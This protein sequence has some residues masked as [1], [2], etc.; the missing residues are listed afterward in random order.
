[1]S[2]DRVLVEEMLRGD[3]DAFARLMRKYQ[4]PLLASAYHLLGQAE[5]AQDVA[6][7]TFIEAYRCLPTLRDGDKLRA[8]L[9]AMLRFRCL[10]FRR[11]RRHV[12]V[13]LEQI[14]DLPASPAPEFA[15][16]A[17]WEALLRLPLTDREIIAARYLQELNFAEIAGVLDISVH[18]AEVRCARVRARLRAILHEMDEE[19]TRALMRQAIAALP[20]GLIG[21]AFLHQV[22][23]EVKSMMYAQ[24]L[25]APAAQQLPTFHLLAHAAAWKTVAAVSIA[26]TVIGAA[27]VL[28][29]RLAKTV[30]TRARR[31]NHGTSCRP[32]AHAI[33]GS[34]GIIV[35]S[36]TGA[37]PSTGRQTVATARSGSS[38]CFT[39]Q[40]IC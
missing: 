20:A 21:D 38:R 26:A 14:A 24:T 30:T 19:E 40:Q 37:D 35:I 7:E 32:G 22:I 15:G 36:D 13:P 39:Q 29:P 18:N 33:T 28:A 9:F 3:A 25:T 23:Q 17:V 12:E 8:W 11:R 27:T 6:Q 31:G 16:H 10:H 5:D 34:C 4:A 2:D 1:M